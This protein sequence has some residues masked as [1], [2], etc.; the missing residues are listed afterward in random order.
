MAETGISRETLKQVMKEA[1]SETLRE[2]RDLLRDVFLEV[3]ED[4]ALVEAIEEGRKTEK[5]SRERIFD[6]LESRS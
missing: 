2:Q 3:I 5:V 1:L 4:I 6:V